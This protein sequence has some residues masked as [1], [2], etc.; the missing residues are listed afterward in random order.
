MIVELLTS[1]QLGTSDFLISDLYVTI[2]LNILAFF[3]WNV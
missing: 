2:L 3:V 1:V